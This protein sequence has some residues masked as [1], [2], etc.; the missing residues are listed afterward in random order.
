MAKKAFSNK[1][2]KRMALVGEAIAF[3]RRFPDRF[4]EEILEI[5]LNLYQKV[6]MRAYF[7]K[8]YSMWVLSRGLGR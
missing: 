4:C 6:L 1:Q 5:K 8:K 7:G 3:Y 2:R